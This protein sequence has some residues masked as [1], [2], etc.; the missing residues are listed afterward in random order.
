MRLLLTGDQLQGRHT[1]FVDGVRRELSETP[2]A[3]LTELSLARL[4][5][6]GGW[7]PI[8]SLQAAGGDK[9]IA[10]QQICRLR[11]QLQAC[12]LIENNSAGAYRLIFGADEIGAAETLWNLT[13][14]DFNITLLKELHKALT[15]QQRRINFLATH[16]SY[17]T[18]G[19][20]SERNLV[21]IIK[22]TAPPVDCNSP[23]QLI[24]SL[25]AIASAASISNVFTQ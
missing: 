12:S 25:P 16:T 4:A 15:R 6:T 23:S 11:E 9:Q 24:I 2:F 19:S 18:R 20:H 10:R 13:S 1:V 17:V 7:L 22:A 5:R 21:A 14:H 8:A 3:V